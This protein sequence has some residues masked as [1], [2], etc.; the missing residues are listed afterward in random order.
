LYNII[1]VLM[2][3]TSPLRPSF[4]S[5]KRTIRDSNVTKYPNLTHKSPALDSPYLNE[6]S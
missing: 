3:G 2:S 5:H 1:F 6:E 4:M